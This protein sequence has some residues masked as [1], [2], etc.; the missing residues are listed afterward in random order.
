MSSSGGLMKL[1][2]KIQLSLVAL[3][4]VV[5]FQNCRLVEIPPVAGP[6]PAT[7]QIQFMHYKL[8][9]SYQ[10]R[11]QGADPAALSAWAE[12]LRLFAPAQ[13]AA[14]AIFQRGNCRV[15]GPI[16][17]VDYR[18]LAKL[19]S[20]STAEASQGMVADAAEETLEVVDRMQVS[21]TYHLFESTKPVVL[22][23][24]RQAI[25]EQLRK[26]AD[27]L[28]RVSGACEKIDYSFHAFQQLTYTHKPGYGIRPMPSKQLVIYN[29]VNASELVRA[30]LN[31]AGC[32]TTHF[33]AKQELR[34]ISQMINTS[35]VG[36]PDAIAADAAEITLDT[37]SFTGTQNSYVLGLPF[38]GDQRTLSNGDKIRA[39][40][41]V[42][43]ARLEA[44]VDCRIPVSTVQ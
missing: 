17:E 8:G 38:R 39:R 44:L 28:V 31:V 27:Y 9:H 22:L 4:T 14:K 33:I 3:L 25:K 21:R 18:D 32:M 23:S 12:E 6:V 40:F 1:T 2:N 43:M 41:E 30:D 42:I 5:A 11:P 20:E 34:E 7:D 19:V 36:V 10:V 37:L 16:S 24:K 15:E 35:S 26:I 29:N 13:G